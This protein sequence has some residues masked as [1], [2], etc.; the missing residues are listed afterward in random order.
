[1]YERLSGRALIVGIGISLLTASTALAQDRF[2]DNEPDWW[3][4]VA[5][6][7]TANLTSDYAE[8]QR[9]GL[10]NLIYLT[11]FYREHLPLDLLLQAVVEVST[12]A[13]SEVNQTLARA[14]LISI[15]SPAAIAYLHHNGSRRQE[16]LA[17][18]ELIRVLQD[19]RGHV[20]RF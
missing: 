15:G 8:I 5:L 9:I 14:L 1:M 7:A 19:Q 2:A 4:R 12:Q 6:Q 10:E 11:V 18:V 20:N 3:Q 17:R 16:Q 13:S